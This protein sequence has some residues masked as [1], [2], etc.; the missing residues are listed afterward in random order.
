MDW[1]MTGWTCI[2]MWATGAMMDEEGRMV[3]RASLPVRE[4]TLNRGFRL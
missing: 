1:C 2:G 3:K 4:N